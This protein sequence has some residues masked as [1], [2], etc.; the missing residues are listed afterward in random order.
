MGE[1]RNMVNIFH[2]EMMDINVR[3]GAYSIQKA[4]PNLLPLQ[5][6]EIDGVG[7]LKLRVM[8]WEN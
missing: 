5:A 3:L 2:K 7:R 4:V 1:K 6:N 8:K